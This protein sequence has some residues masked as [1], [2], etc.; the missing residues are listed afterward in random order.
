M[1]P[2][3]EHGKGILKIVYRVRLPFPN[4]LVSIRGITIFSLPYE[5]AW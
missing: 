5:I 4:R 1:I 2:K 3:L